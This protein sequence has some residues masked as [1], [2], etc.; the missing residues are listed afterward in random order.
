[1]QGS[2]IENKTIE[3]IAHSDVCM[4]SSIIETKTIE[5]MANSDV[6]MLS[7]IIEKYYKKDSQ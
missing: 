3:K 7:S 1:M 4:L 2:I 6:C 5:K